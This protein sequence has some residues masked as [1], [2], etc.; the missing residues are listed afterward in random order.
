[1]KELSKENEDFRQAMLLLLDD[2]RVAGEKKVAAAA[3]DL[4]IRLY[5]VRQKLLK[6]GARESSLRQGLMESYQNGPPS[7]LKFMVV[8]AERL[9]DKDRKFEE[10][11]RESETDSLT[12]SLN[13]FRFGK[14]F[15]T[16]FE[17]YSKTGQDFT[18]VIMDLGG[19]KKI[20]DTYGH[21]VGDVA[22]KSFYRT[23]VNTTRLMDSI[24]RYG[25]DEFVLLL[26]TNLEVAKLVVERIIEGLEKQNTNIAEKNTRELLFNLSA[27]FGFASASQIP[28]DNLSVETLLEAADRA[29]YLTKKTK[30]A[31]KEQPEED[32]G[33]IE[34]SY[35][36]YDPDSDYKDFVSTRT[37]ASEE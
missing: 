18:L 14:D 32:P 4:I 30:K 12:G 15:N 3:A 19:L 26:S 10:A 27:S 13:R 8:A 28:K 16:H 22:I 11:E 24:Y 29:Q 25:G 2:L 5:D 35:S 9:A 33:E 37:E 23:I 36:I 7:A 20:N 34:F 6:D 1:M 21:V 31:K 17:N